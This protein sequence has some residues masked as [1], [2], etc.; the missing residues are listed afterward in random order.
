MKTLVLIRHAK[1]SWEHDITDL[2]RPL[3]KRGVNDAALLSKSLDSLQ[4]IPDAIFSSPANRALSTCKIFMNNL[5]Y[6]EQILSIEEQLYDFGGNR[7]L[8]FIKN[9]D[10]VYD[11]VILFGHNHAF[12][13]LTNTLG[14]Q[15]LDNLPTSG[16]VMIEFD[17]DSWKKIKK[18]HTKMIRKPKDLK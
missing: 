6:P 18:G 15:S 1:S 16:F 4:Y 2:K 13:E 11:Q 12:T 7:V 3:S 14:N 9:L 5:N 17:V 10:D 8:R